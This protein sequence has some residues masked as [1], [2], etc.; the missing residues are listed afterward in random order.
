MKK[1]LLFVILLIS[2]NVNSQWTQISQ[3]PAP[4][5]GYYSCITFYN[6]N[7]GLASLIEW[8]G[9]RLFK[10]TDGGANWTENENSFPGF[11]IGSICFASSDSIFLSDSQNGS[12]YRSMDGGL[13]YQP[14]NLGNFTGKFY[15]RD[16]L[17]GFYYANTIID[18]GIKY[19]FDGGLTW[20]GPTYPGGIVGISFPDANSSI[21]YA[22]YQSGVTYKSI[23]DGIHWDRIAETGFAQYSSLHFFNE[24]FGYRLGITKLEKTI[25]GGI[26]WSLVNDLG[27]GEMLFTDNATVGY[28][29]SHHNYTAGASNF[30][31]QT[32][33]SGNYWNTM[34]GINI[35]AEE[36]LSDIDFPT[37]NIGFAVTSNGTIYKYDFVLNVNANNF[38]PFKVYPNPVKEI[39]FIEGNN[40]DLKKYEIYDISGKKIA[41]GLIKN[42]Q[43]SVNTLVYGLY[44]IKIDEYGSLKF[45]KE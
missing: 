8:A 16:H 26:S 1:S 31:Y 11:R 34:T 35:S 24:Q 27:G 29:N 44:F 39:L 28:I 38:Y 41:S 23:D 14:F 33:T 36:Y 5:N 4:T 6:E 32:T 13:T 37:N 12:C 45:N 21:G 30:I 20:N 10:T 7:Y 40:F 25:D 19:T 3:L 17:R 42:N 18:G 15:F 2:I 43:I 22:L 9:S